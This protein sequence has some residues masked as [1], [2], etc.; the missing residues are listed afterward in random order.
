MGNVVKTLFGGGAKPQG[1]SR[2]EL[3]MQKDARDRAL[4]D[5]AEAERLAALS[6]QAGSRRK[7]LSYFDPNAKQVLGG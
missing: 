7:S 1:P 3:Q 6:M 2:A 4:K 5:R